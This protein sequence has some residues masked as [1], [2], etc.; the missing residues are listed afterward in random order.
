MTDLPEAGEALHPTQVA[1][2]ATDSLQVPQE[3][4]AENEQEQLLLLEPQEFLQGAV[5]LAQVLGERSVF[6]RS[7]SPVWDGLELLL[8]MVKVL[9]VRGRNLPSALAIRTLRDLWE[10]W[11]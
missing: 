8:R 9:R 11:E 2:R 10:N 3:G 5:Q 1:S 7:C 6:G 4:K